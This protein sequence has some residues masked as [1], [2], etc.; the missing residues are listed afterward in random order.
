MIPKIIHLCWLSGD[1]YPPLIQKCIASWAEF[2]PDYEVI[3]WDA[4]A[5]ERERFPAWVYQAVAA[6]KYAFAADYIRLFALHRHGGFYL[7]S[8]VQVVRSFDQFLGEQSV[9]GRETSGDLEP[10]V[11]GSLPAQ[12]WTKSCLDYYQDRPFIK[13]DGQPDQT[14]LPI[15]VGAV[16]T[17]SYGLQHGAGYCAAAG[18]RVHE[19]AV[20]SP[21]CRI[22]SE[23]LATAATCSIHHFDGQWVERST[24]NRAKELIHVGLIRLFGRSFHQQT[25]QFV[26]GI[27]ER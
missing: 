25:V 9:M 6:K 5:L 27:V 12:R 22:T 10:A 2:L 23:V 26:R 21:K 14:P 8:D 20:F 13:A 15:I 18:L 19:A 3:L 7:D 24:R 17:E 11:I 1:P 4:A 16:L